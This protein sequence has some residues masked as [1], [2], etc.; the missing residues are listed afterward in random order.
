MAFGISRI[1]L[2]E[3]KAMADRGEISY[4][5]HYW[6]E[7]RFPGIKTITKVG[8]SNLDKLTKWCSM[9]G[10][11]AKYIH[12]RSEYPHFDLLG[13]KQKEILYKENQ[14]DQIKRFGI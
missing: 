12:H 4:L 13:A 9:N 1:E 5:T 6:I 14:W 2:V 11:N 3:W 7:P 10:L 8:C